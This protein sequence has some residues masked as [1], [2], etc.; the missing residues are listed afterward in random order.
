MKRLQ[1][2]IEEELDQAL[3]AQARREGTSKAALVRRCIRQ[4][5]GRAR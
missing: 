5:L 2:R 3:E 4:G 1:F